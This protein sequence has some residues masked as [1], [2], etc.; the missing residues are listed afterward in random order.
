MSNADADDGDTEDDG[1]AAAGD[2]TLAAA[3]ADAIVMEMLKMMA[4]DRSVGRSVGWSATSSSR[5]E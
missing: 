5:I 1:A 3:D 4:V 2:A